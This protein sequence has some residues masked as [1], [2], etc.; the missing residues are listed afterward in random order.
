MFQGLTL[1]GFLAAGFAVRPN[2]R[3]RFTTCLNGSPDF[4][5]SFFSRLATSSSS[6]RVVRTS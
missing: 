5:A 3:N 6:V 4:R 1:K 2:R